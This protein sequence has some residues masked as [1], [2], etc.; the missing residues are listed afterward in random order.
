[1]IGRGTTSARL[2]IFRPRS[3]DHATSIT[4]DSDARAVTLKGYSL[5]VGTASTLDAATALRDKYAKLSDVPVFLTQIRDSNGLHYEIEM[6]LFNAEN[7][8]K[9]LVQEL[10]DAGAKA[11]VV[12]FQSGIPQP[13]TV[14][15][16]TR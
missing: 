4:F 11:E 3:S 1:M 14:T 5:R 9:L 16:A 7:S 15:V 8:C 12:R 13:V 10:G 6:G 2:E